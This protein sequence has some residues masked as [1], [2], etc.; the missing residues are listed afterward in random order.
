MKSNQID[1]NC[2]ENLMK[3]N[4]IESNCNEGMEQYRGSEWK[5]EKIEWLK[6]T[7]GVDRDAVMLQFLWTREEL[8]KCLGE[9]EA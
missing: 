8:K 2:N 7:W 1:S 4:E 6:D 5:Q 3:Y 9:M